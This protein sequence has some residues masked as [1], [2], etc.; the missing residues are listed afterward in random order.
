MATLSYMRDKKCILIKIPCE[1][2]LSPFCFLSP[3][4]C[5]AFCPCYPFPF[6]TQNLPLVLIQ[7]AYI[8]IFFFVFTHKTDL[9]ILSLDW[10]LFCFFIE[11]GLYCYLTVFELSVISLRDFSMFSM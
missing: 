1:S 6:P 9:G 5:P 10:I 7:C 3:L 8:Q 4:L 11:T 2:S